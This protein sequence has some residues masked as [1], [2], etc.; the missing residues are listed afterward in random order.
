MSTWTDHPTPVRLAAP[1][2]R[3][4]ENTVRLLLVEDS[5]TCITL[6]LAALGQAERGR[7]EVECASCVAAAEMLLRHNPAFD[8]VLVDLTV[9]GDGADGVDSICE[10]AHRVPVVALTGT[11][12][13]A[14]ERAAV[15][16]R[17]GDEPLHRIGRSDLSA[18]ILRA[19]HRHRRLGVCGAEPI[20]CR[21]PSA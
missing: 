17:V 6:L 20:V 5:S 9:P 10:F 13:G 14:L 8:A 18:T 21:I 7:F 16:D 1:D 15:D 3:R 11:Q 4:D 2:L 19:V 12:D